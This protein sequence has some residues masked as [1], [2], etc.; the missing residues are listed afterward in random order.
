MPRRIEARKGRILRRIYDR[1][2]EVYGPQHWWPAETPFEVMVGTIL[3][4]NTNWA[5]VEKAIQ[6]LK[7]R[8]CLSLNA[9]RALSENELAGLIRPAGTFRV[10]ARRLRN[11]LDL[12]A[13]WGSVTRMARAPLDVLRRK[14][15][16]VNGVGPETADSILLYARQKPVFVVDAYTRRLLDRHGFPEGRAGYD[17]IQALFMRHC[18]RDV[19]VYNEYHALIVRLGKDFKGLDAVRR[20]EYPLKA[21]H[22]FL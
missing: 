7:D 3:V 22:F 9:L 11:L 4:Q 8:K 20:K 5:N 13:G 15:L 1:L 2:C 16:D 6:A 17:D 12:I 19:R 10:K 21:A 18:P 14:L